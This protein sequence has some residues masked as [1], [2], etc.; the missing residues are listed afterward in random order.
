MGGQKISFRPAVDIPSL[1]GKV[2]LITGGNSGLGKQSAIDLAKHGPA[3]VWIAGRNEDKARP[4]LASIQEAASD[5]GTM[6]KFLPLDLGS[7]ASVAK[8]AETFCAAVDRLDMLFLN[9]GIMDVVP[10]LT[11]D[12]YEA[13]FGTNHMG[14]AL[15]LKLLTP[16]LLRTAAHAASPADV[17]VVVVSSEGHK[18]SVPGGIR[19]DTLKTNGWNMS[20]LA[21]YGQ[22]KMANVI[23]ASEVAKRYP[24]WTT[25]SLHP[26]T[27]KT[28]LHQSGDGESLMLRVFQ[29]VLLPFVGLPVDKGVHNHLWAATAKGVVSGEYYEPV[30]V[31]GKAHR[32]ATDGLLGSE[33][34]NWTEHELKG[35]EAKEM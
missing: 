33:L 7:F 22:S 23:F 12:G 15:L 30:G 29:K 3:Q 26:G 24:Q 14:H 11:A 10:S 16:L 34:W 21:R 20:S 2:I 13:Q 5:A 6:V 25:V 4:A 18:Y 27:V 1:A 32:T 28:E 9:A 35:F 19:F 8:A 17:R 31:G